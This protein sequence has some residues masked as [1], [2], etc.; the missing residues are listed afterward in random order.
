[1]STQNYGYSSLHRIFRDSIRARE[2]AEYL[3][4]VDK[5]QSLTKV[6]EFMESKDYDVIGVREGGAVVG[7]ILREDCQSGKIS[8]HLIKFREED[9]LPEGA[10]LFD[11][12]N[13]LKTRRWTFIQY[14]ENPGGIITRGDLQ[15]TPVRLWLFGVISLLEMQLLRLIRTHYPEDAWKTYLSE[16]RI[17]AAEKVFADRIKDNDGIDLAECLQIGDKKAIFKKSEILFSFTGLQSKGAWDDF[18]KELEK[19]RNKLAHS[20]SIPSSSW[21]EIT[22]LALQMES[23]LSHIEKQ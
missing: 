3:V 15:K 10:T 16:K 23:C 22:K 13:A 4:S 19:L 7:Y 11:A 2:I 18:M 14:L 6:V 20:N 21:P 8:D 1:M 17:E 12:L 9:M 5:D